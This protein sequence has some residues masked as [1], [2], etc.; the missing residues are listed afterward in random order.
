M[1]QADFLSGVTI[2]LSRWRAE[3]MTA[4]VY[5]YFKLSTGLAS[6]VFRIWRPIEINTITH[7]NKPIKK[8]MD[9]CIGAL[10][11]KF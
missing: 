9:I 3:T 1:C 6:D 7:D 2:K 8:N 10:Y 5:S 11:A 4:A